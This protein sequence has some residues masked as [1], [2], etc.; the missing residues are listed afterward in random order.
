MTTILTTTP[1]ADGYAM[2][3]EFAPHDACW[4][5]FPFRPDV[6]R[7]DAA[8]QVYGQIVRAI[9]QFETV[10]IGVHPDHHAA[11]Q[12][13]L[14]DAANVRLLPLKY[15]DIW[16][17]DC[18]ATCV[19]DGR[20]GV[21]AV[22]WRFNAWGELYAPYD[23]DDAVAGAMAADLGVA[24]Y[25][26]PLV[27]EGGALHVDG[28]GTLITTKECLLSATRNPDLSQA[29][30]EQYLTDYLGVRKVIWLDH[31]VYMDETEGHVDNLCCFV[32]PG[33]LALT[34]TDDTNDPQY[35]ISRAAYDLLR[36]STD[37][38]GRPCE[39]HKITQPGPLYFTEDEL[40][41]LDT[42][43]LNIDF[44]AGDRLPV[45]YVNFY[46]ANGGLVVPTYNAPQDQ[47]ALQTLAALFPE[48]RVVGVYA[49]EIALGGGSIHCIT[50][51]QPRP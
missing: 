25:D 33:V 12:S 48:R 42:G 26:A 29:Q 40:Q 35:D 8:R 16:M 36:S 51:Q 34:W 9:A 44:A 11:A 18:G 17:R 45:S 14:G 20:G 10:N 43:E 47:A 46:I 6:W 50:Q 4:M 31:G 49:R 23:D 39:V 15:N 22:N 2:P 7:V 41:T 24:R 38:H 21:R 1:R 27:M 37:A 13:L 32:R 28:E 5:L 19:T 3:A 30:I